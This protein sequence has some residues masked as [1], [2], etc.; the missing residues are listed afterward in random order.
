MTD[1]NWIKDLVKFD[2]E[3]E[4]SGIID[5]AAGFDPDK[6]IVSQS[7]E[8]ITSLK[9]SFVDLATTFNQLKG[10][11]LGS[12]KVYGISNTHADFMLFRNG[13]KLIF[14]LEEAGKISIKSRH[15]GLGFVP[16]SVASES[17]KEKEHSDRFLVARWGAF[18]ELK[19]FFD[20]QEVNKDF[21]VRYYISKFVRESAK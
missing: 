12:I 15:Q 4:E 8:F 2:Q 14:S 19:W 5:M 3:I 9:N 18:G 7:F 20:E 10:T 21:L 17:K 11:T 13:F 6:E 1:A 16:G